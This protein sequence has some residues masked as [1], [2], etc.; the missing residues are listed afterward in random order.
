MEQVHHRHR[1][2]RCPGANL[3]IV[4]SLPL[5]W[6]R[7]KSGR[8]GLCPKSFHDIT[9]NRYSVSIRRPLMV[10]LWLLG[11][12]SMYLYC[13]RSTMLQNEECNEKRCRHQG[14]SECE[15]GREL[16]RWTG[17]FISE[18][19]ICSN[20]KGVGK[21]RVARVG[22]WSTLAEAFA[23]TDNA[24]DTKPCGHHRIPVSRTTSP[25]RA[26]HWVYSNWVVSPA[27]MVC[28]VASSPNSRPIRC[29]QH[30]RTRHSPQA[31][32]SSQPASSY[33]WVSPLRPPLPYT[34]TCGL[35]ADLC[36]VAAKWTSAWVIPVPGTSIVP[37]RLYCWRRVALI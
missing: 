1:H 16:T 35:W 5:V 31:Q 23:L 12:P 8:Y 37:V 36:S 30:I 15:R 6:A 32:S 19:D 4:W 3:N 14:R 7:V 21:G 26:S 13:S 27:V 10:S 11:S 34:L 24:H 29:A 17:N 18:C 2:H 20:C 25:N 33:R 28:P 22:G 9:E